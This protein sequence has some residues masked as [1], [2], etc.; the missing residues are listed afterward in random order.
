[1]PNGVE[2]P[3]GA[4]SVMLSP[5]LTR[6]MLASRMPSATPSC[7]IETIERAEADVVGDQR[8]LLDTGLGHAAH[9][10]AER[11]QC[12]EIIAWPSI[13]GSGAP[14]RR[15]PLASRRAASS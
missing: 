2:A 3:F 4:T 10:R 5:T 11:L 13:S 9:Q 14:D 12:D 6:R 15:A 7:G 1:M 8:Q